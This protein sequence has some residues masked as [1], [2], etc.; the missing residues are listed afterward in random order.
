MASMSSSASIAALPAR[1]SP[2]RSDASMRSRFSATRTAMTST[3]SRSCSSSPWKPDLRFTPAS[4]E[5]TGDVVLGALVA[6]VRE[7]L[8]GVVVL[9]EH[10]GPGVADLVHLGGE[11]RAA[12]AH[13]GRLLHVVGD[14]HD[15]VLGL[16]L[17]HEILDATGGDRIERGARL[18]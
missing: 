3:C 4:S 2:S 11:E 15:R 6:R 10:A 1:S 8:L 18:V 5:A 16:D 7:H 17:V 12:V 13:A 14:D 9:D